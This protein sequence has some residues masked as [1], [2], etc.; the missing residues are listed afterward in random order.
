[1]FVRT[2]VSPKKGDFGGFIKQERAQQVRHQR[3]CMPSHKIND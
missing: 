1:M 3:T 2:K